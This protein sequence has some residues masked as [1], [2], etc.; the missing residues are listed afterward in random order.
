MTPSET[1]PVTQADREAAAAWAK[2]LI[3]AEDIYGGRDPFFAASFP[4]SL[5]AGVFD[6]HDLAQAFAKHRIAHTPQPAAG[7]E[8]LPSDWDFWLRDSI[9]ILQANG[10]DNHVANLRILF[11]ALTRATATDARGK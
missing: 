2:W 10:S 6:D 11:A 9:E 8:E 5:Y 4:A 7:V 3:D 1:V